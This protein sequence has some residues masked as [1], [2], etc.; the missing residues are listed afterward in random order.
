VG[1]IHVGNQFIAVEHFAGTVLG[2]ASPDNSGGLGVFI[3]CPCR[4]RIFSN[5]GRTWRARQE[6]LS[7]LSVCYLLSSPNA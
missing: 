6:I 5:A 7:P 3:G 4:A 2:S 1:L